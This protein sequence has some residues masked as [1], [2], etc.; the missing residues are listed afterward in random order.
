MQ[1]LRFLAQ[2][3]GRAVAVG[4]VS[5]VAA[6]VAAQEA[7]PAPALTPE[8]PARRKQR[9]EL[10]KQG[11][12]L[13]QEGKWAEA[14]A[15][16]EQKLAIEREVLGENDQ[17]TLDTLLQVAELQ[18]QREDFPAARQAAQEVLTAGTRLRGDT[19]WQVSDARLFLSHVD[20][21]E[22][23]TSA[24]RRRLAEAAQLNARVKALGEDGKYEE[25]LPLA[26]QALEI[27]RELLGED[28][29]D[30]LMSLKNLGWML[31]DLNRWEESE[32]LL[33]QTLEG[34]RRVQGQQHPDYAYT[35][36]VLGWLH[37]YRQ[38]WDQ[39]EACFR[40]AWE[41]YQRLGTDKAPDRAM[42]ANNLAQVLALRGDYAQAETYYREA[43]AV[44]K[45]AGGEHSREY[46]D[47]LHRLASVFIG[48]GDFPRAEPLCQQALAICRELR[49]EKHVDFLRCLNTLADLY[50][51][52]GDYLQAEQLCRRALEIWRELRGDRHPGTAVLLSNLAVV[53]Q[54]QQE[55]AKAEPLH[56]QALTIRKQVLGEQHLEYANSLWNLG[57]FYLQQ[58]DFVPAET[59]LIQSLEVTRRALGMRNDLVGDGLSSLAELYR[60]QGALAKAERSWRQAAEAYK[61]VLG[62]Q[63]PW[64]NEAVIAL[65]EVCSAQGDD[66]Q[67]APL[68][69][70]A[71]ERSRLH[72]DLCAAIQSERQQLAMNGKYRHFLDS[73]LG[74]TARVPRSA[75]EVY[76]WVLLWKGAVLVRQQHARLVRAEP[77]FA[78]QAERL[79]S[80]T[81][82]I[83]RL[84]FASSD[85]KQAAPPRTR[86]EELTREKEEL[87]SELSKRSTA[88]VRQQEQQRLTPEQLRQA[89]PSD[90][91]LVDFLEYEHRSFDGQRAEPWTTESRLVAFILRGGVPIQRVDVGPTK[92]VADAL[93]RWRGTLMRFRPRLTE[94]DPAVAL[95]RLI[96][97]PLE[98]HLGDV[99]T[100][101][102]SPDGLLNELPFAALP[103]RDA[104]KY[105]LEERAVGVL[106]VPQCLPE[107]LTHQD[108]TP[109]DATPPS[110]LA[111]GEIDYDARATVAEP[112]TAVTTGRRRRAGSLQH[113]GQLPATRGEVLAIVDSFRQAVPDGRTT[114][115]TG[116]GATEAA[117][118][119]Q[120][121]Q[122]RYLHLA[123]HGFFA[124]ADVK[125]ALGT[126][127][128][129]SGE[130]DG[131]R[132]GAVG[133]H[134]GLLS[135]V[136]LAGANNPGTELGDDDGVLTA[137][138]VSELDLR[139]VEVAVLSACETG[140]GRVAGGEGVLGL[141]RAFQLAGAKTVV[142]SLWKVDDE[143]TRSLMEA[144]YQN[145]WRDQKGMLESLREAQLQMLREGRQR[146]LLRELPPDPRP[147]RTP[148]YYWA[149]FVLSGDWR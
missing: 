143:A 18:L 147:V 36:C 115:L 95:R 60:V 45:A 80:V 19:D 59:F 99:P 66:R 33:T 149:A 130:L 50:Q 112:R 92:P 118:R 145:Y 90:V 86:V 65:A 16:A 139:R 144:F 27:R 91:A 21:V 97:E 104:D 54:K 25:A 3:C 7:V 6:L 89:L 87:E 35:L 11:E 131:D 106:A 142:T 124:A 44:R 55:F 52:Q 136:V 76:R 70:E 38:E 8:Q 40:R 46:A 69:D 133:F 122:H 98:P 108:S 14:F 109:Q 61:A 134:P 132:V 20:R 135:G 71:L 148:P 17:D 57:K 141:Q 83:A 63:S 110:M 56:Q 128:E 49:G 101:L 129:R 84:A 64:Y 67:S 116:A 114:V 22:R 68:Y 5:L 140:R 77:Q 62:E 1:R 53:Y 47:S 72:L 93:D 43:L 51:S 81:A 123:T 117:L 88:F 34:R 94:P 42:A 31:R 41:T 137:L 2:P 4:V 12:A 100:V 82:E 73:F 146:G 10:G 75:E 29:P 58:R 39:A 48:Q 37:Y 107:L 32:P 120:A 9:D 28:H 121:V 15:V 23:L 74:F 78:P 111:L 125:S 138:E 102:V 103:G 127:A 105:L 79:R 96:W 26:R 13:R 30:T 113:W 24:Q 85:P 126:G 119:R